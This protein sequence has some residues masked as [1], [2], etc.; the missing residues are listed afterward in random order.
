VTRLLK[1]S[2]Q[3][4][5]IP[6][7]RRA[8]KLYG[9]CSLHIFGHSV[10]RIPLSPANHAGSAVVNFLSFSGR[11]HQ[12][13]S[14]RFH[15][16]NK[17]ATSSVFSVEQV[18]NEV[19]EGNISDEDTNKPVPNLEDVIK[20]S[21][22]QFYPLRHQLTNYS[23]FCEE[24]RQCLGNVYRRHESEGILD[25]VEKVLS[26]FPSIRPMINSE[27]RFWVKN[28]NRRIRTTPTA[29][30][31]WTVEF[32]RDLPEQVFNHIRDAVRKG[33][34]T[35]GVHVEDSVIKFT[36]KKRLVRD[37]SKLSSLVQSEISNQLKKSFGGKKKNF[38][39]EVLVSEDKPFVIRF[40]Y[41]RM[42]VTVAC[43]YGCW[44]EFGY[45]FHG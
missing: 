39:A 29:R 45:G 40:D 20:D 42:K 44:N 7:Y 4:S 3:P 14:Q 2:L 13:A 8:W 23:R 15:I 11:D 27:V 36:E 10:F 33:A 38:K 34:S 43:N 22:A 32:K 18:V 37:F 28:I 35:Y 41:K 31:P 16:R 5:S 17:M 12:S 9:K 6:T 19:C 1:S 25:N 24:V 30:S 26:D 21:V